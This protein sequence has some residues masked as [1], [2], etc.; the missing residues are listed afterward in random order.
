MTIFP[1]AIAIYKGREVAVQLFRDQMG[2][3]SEVVLNNSIESMEY[4][5][6]NAIRKLR[7]KLNPKIAFIE[8]HGEWDSLHV[9]D[10]TAALSEYYVVDRIQLK[11]QLKKLSQL[12]DAAD[13]TAVELRH[14]ALT[15]L[16][17]IT[18]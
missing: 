14:K 7:A 4:E 18:S 8:G 2:V 13:L 10:I 12:N 11:G 3:P 15:L 5:L 9:A 1:G 16:R 6:S 17:S